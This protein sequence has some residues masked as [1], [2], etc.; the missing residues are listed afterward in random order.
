MSAKPWI[1]LL[2]LLG[3][4]ALF[5]PFVP[6]TQASGHFLG[7]RYQQTADVSPTYYLFHCGSYENTKVT[8]Q[9]GSGFTGLYQLSQGYNFACNYQ[10][11]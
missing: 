1:A 8:T 7:A 4:V 9:I 3:A 2:V 5:V 6:Q 10:S 11:Q